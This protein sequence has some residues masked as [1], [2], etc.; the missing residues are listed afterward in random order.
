[1][2]HFLL[3]YGC[4]ALNSHVESAKTSDIS[5]FERNLCKS[6]NCPVKP[7][8]DTVKAMQ[9]NRLHMSEGEKAR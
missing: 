3:T 5:S 1:M 8:S 2:Q 7:E 9:K 4:I 6:R